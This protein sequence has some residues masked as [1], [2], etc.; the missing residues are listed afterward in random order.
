MFVLKRGLDATPY[1][2]APDRGAYV[3]QTVQ[4]DLRVGYYRTLL[5]STLTPAT[6]GR[7]AIEFYNRSQDH[8][9]T[10]DSAALESAV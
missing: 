2:S 5:N 9:L 1:S 10:P 8:Y 4:N 3:G 6:A 7:Y